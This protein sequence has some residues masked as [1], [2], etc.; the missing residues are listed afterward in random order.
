MAWG[1]PN[2][3][4][5][6]TQLLSST[7]FLY[8]FKQA[9]KCQRLSP[10]LDKVLINPFIGRQPALSHTF[11][12]SVLLMVIKWAIW[13]TELS[14]VPA[15]CGAELTLP[16]CDPVIRWQAG[17]CHSLHLGLK[18]RPPASWFPANSPSP[19]SFMTFCTSWL[20]VLVNF[21]NHSDDK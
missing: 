13:F 5:R 21:L 10:S 12:E 4:P 3:V 15:R 1:C 9:A 6:G 16:R 8:G 19:L 2:W 20:H 11:L 18:V 17:I 14:K 7:L